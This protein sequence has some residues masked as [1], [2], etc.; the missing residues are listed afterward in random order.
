MRVPFRWLKRRGIVPHFA[1][2]T[3]EHTPERVKSSGT[4]PPAARTASQEPGRSP[5]AAPARAGARRT[6]RKPGTGGGQPPGTQSPRGGPIRPS[7]K[8]HPPPRGRPRAGG[9]GAG[10]PGCGRLWGMPQR[11]RT[12][13]G[14]ARERRGGRAAGGKIRV[15][16]R[17]RVT[18]PA[19][20]PP[21]RLRLTQSTGDP[22]ARAAGWPTGKPT[23]SRGGRRE[24]R[25]EAA[26]AGRVR[27]EPHYPRAKKKRSTPSLATSGALKGRSWWRTDTPEAAIA[28][29]RRPGRE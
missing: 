5:Q 26:P 7:P 8:R 1:M 13:A 20:R 15:T 24:E 3:L 25:P 29:H 12:A 27:P 19:D 18:P 4:T 14:R 22:A 10:A 23:A 9:L 2:D 11:P 17:L 6:R 21:C 16:S 28:A